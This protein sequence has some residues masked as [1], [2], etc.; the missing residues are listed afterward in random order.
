MIINKED[1]ESGAIAAIRSFYR[2]VAVIAD[3]G[4]CTHHT[5]ERHGI[6]DVFN[7]TQKKQAPERVWMLEEYRGSDEHYAA[8]DL[9]IC[10]TNIKRKVIVADA[11]LNCD[12][13]GHSVPSTRI[14][15]RKLVFIPYLAFEDDIPDDDHIAIQ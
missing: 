13:N 2:L 14:P 1:D 10:L 5:A 11:T 15:N 8:K 12:G 4:G 9:P 7:T 3:G 6:C